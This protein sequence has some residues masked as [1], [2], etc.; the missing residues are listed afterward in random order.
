[1]LSS[2][3]ESSRSLLP[4]P[5]VRQLPGLERLSL[6]CALRD[7]W[8]AHA[9]STQPADRPQAEDAVTELYRRIGAPRPRFVWVP[10]PAAARSELR[11]DP[12]VFRPARLRSDTTP[13]HG[14]DWPLA[15][16]LASLQSDLRTRM[17]AQISRAAPP[18]QWYPSGLPPARAL[19]PE[20]AVDAGVPLGHVLA[21]TVRDALAASVRDAVRAPVRTGLLPASGDS[22]ALTW[23]G[24]HDAH[25]IAHLDIQ[26][27]VGLARYRDSDTRQ[28]ALWATLARSTGWWWPGRGRCVMAERPAEVHTEPAPGGRH[29]EV[30]LHHPDSPAVR[31]ADGAE[32]YALSGTRVPAWVIT[33]P[34]VERIHRETNVEV[35]RC[36]IERIGWDC[37][38]EQAGLQLVDSAADPG[39]PGSDLHLYHVPRQVWGRPARVLLVVNGS[40]EPDGERRRYGLGVPAH[41]GDP[42]AAAG[43][44]YGLT[45]D[46]Y[47]RLLRR[48]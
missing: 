47:S 22:S 25:W 9:L 32:L 18:W 38:I 20:E 1:M 48:T 41:I 2:R 17:D 14:A 6:A 28:L 24:Q 33:D 5:D 15:A 4:L 31:F 26:A 16:R 37:Y 7:D 35:R 3:G 42:V 12:Q 13:A 45:G 21:A 43:W 39:N 36:A 44:S 46:Q 23:Y 19:S 10:S 30:R 29:G 8:L 11:D 27:R 40:V 34:T